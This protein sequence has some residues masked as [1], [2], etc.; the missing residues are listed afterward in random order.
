MTYLSSKVGQKQTQVLSQASYVLVVALFTRHLTQ[1]FKLPENVMIVYITRK[2]VYF[3]LS[4]SACKHMRILMRYK[5][6]EGGVM[7]S[8]S[9][10][11]DLSENR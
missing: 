6:G 7:G 4:N 9:I 10:L 5:V 3:L 11:S 8:D 2:E 1:L